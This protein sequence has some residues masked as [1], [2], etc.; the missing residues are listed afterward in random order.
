VLV[1]GATQITV[2]EPT[3]GPIDDLAGFDIY[4]SESTSGFLLITSTV[5]H[6]PFVH[7][8]LVAGTTHNYVYKIRDVFGQVSPGFSPTAT[9]TTS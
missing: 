8:G 3:Q 5:D 7:S 4:H 9:A 1:A 2:T 6:G